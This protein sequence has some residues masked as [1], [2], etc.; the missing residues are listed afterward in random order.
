MKATFRNGDDKIFKGKT[1]TILKNKL[2][3]TKKHKT[4]LQHDGP[5]VKEGKNMKEH[6]AVYEQIAGLKERKVWY[7]VFNI[8]KFTIE[9]WQLERWS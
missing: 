7:A 9:A 5:M 4:G 1:A 8:K 6:Q 3:N 2:K